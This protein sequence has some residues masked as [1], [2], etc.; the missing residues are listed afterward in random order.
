MTAFG[1]EFRHITGSLLAKA[2]DNELSSSEAAFVTPH[3]AQC[4]ECGEAFEELRLASSRVD[5]LFA[6]LAVE[7]IPFER[8]Q[9]REKLVAADR[10]KRVQQ[11]PER[12]IRRFG[13]GMAIA[14]TLAVGIL[15]VPKHREEQKSQSAANTVADSL[16]VDGETFITLPYSNPDLPMNAPRIVQMQVPL[17]SLADIGIV[18]EPVANEVSGVDRSVLADVLVGTDG[19]PLGVNVLGFE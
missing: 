2:L 3:L 13:L 11:S 14:A 15:V 16:E 6:S 18:L 4:A 17:S 12:V 8:E 9:L 10:L 5:A 1:H 19:Q 7:Q